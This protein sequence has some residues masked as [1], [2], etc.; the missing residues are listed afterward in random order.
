MPIQN[1]TIYTGDKYKGQESDASTPRVNGTGYAEAAIAFG[2][3]LKAGTA[4]DQVLPGHDTGNVLGIAIR[5]ANHEAKFRPSTGE[6]EYPVTQ[7]VSLMREGYINIEVTAR[8]AVKGAFA[9][10]V[11]ATGEFA[12]GAAGAGETAS[13]NVRFMES[14][15]VGDIVRARIDI[16]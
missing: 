16:V 9:N 10:V 6:T 3:A 12:G 2:I 13:V 15:Q 8:A 1:Y 14:G 11:D 4:E 5:E 7:S